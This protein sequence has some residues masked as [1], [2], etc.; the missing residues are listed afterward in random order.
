ML[1]YGVQVWGCHHKLEGL[2]QIQLLAL[3]ILFGAG[4]HHPKASLLMEADA[5]PVA[6]LARV[7]CAAFWFRILSNPLYEWRIL[8][9]AAMETIVSQCLKSFGWCVVG[10]EEKQGLSS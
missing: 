2:S 8:R 5:L 3:R 7:R 9:V 10:A 1:L 6:W 4:L